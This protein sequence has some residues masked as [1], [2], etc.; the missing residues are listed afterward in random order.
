MEEEIDLVEPEADR[1]SSA[2]VQSKSKSPLDTAALLARLDIL[3]DR[4]DRTDAA[5][6]EERQKVATLQPQVDELTAELREV[7]AELALLADQREKGKIAEEPNGYAPF[8]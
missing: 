7:K 4:I 5:L 8:H 6:A 1:P 3:E 2:R